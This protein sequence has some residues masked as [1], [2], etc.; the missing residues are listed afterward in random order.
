MSDECKIQVGKEYLGDHSLLSESVEML[1]YEPVIYPLSDFESQMT[2][3]MR[4]VVDTLDSF[5]DA[6]GKA[7]FD[8]YGLVVPSVKIPYHEGFFGFKGSCGTQRL[9]Q[10]YLGCKS[11]FDKIM[12]ESFAF[13]PILV[14][15]KDHKCY[16]IT[17]WL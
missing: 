8:F 7:I 3:N 12:V 17:Y 4:S 16:F 1:D 2:A 14:A 9:H 13:R 15:E 5:H 6:G 10:D 11:D